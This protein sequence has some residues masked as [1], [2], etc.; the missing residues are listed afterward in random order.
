MPKPEYHI[1]NDGR[2]I[3]IGVEIDPSFNNPL[4]RYFRET[5]HAVKRRGAIW[6]QDPITGTWYSNYT[7]EAPALFLLR[8]PEDVR[9]YIVGSSNLQ[10]VM[11]NA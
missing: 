9:K 11:K 1:T 7:E 2:V 6:E 10:K 4:I 3:N 5:Y 8:L